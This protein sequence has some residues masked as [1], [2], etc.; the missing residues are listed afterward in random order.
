[1]HQGQLEI[2][3]V[4]HVPERSVS[5]RP[6]TARPYAIILA[7][8]PEDVRKGSARNTRR[9]SRSGHL[10]VVALVASRVSSS[11]GV[12]TPG[13]RRRKSFPFHVHARFISRRWIRARS[14]RS[15]RKYGRCRL[16]HVG[17]EVSAGPYPPQPLPS[18]I[19]ISAHPGGIGRQLSASHRVGIAEVKTGSRTSRG[20]SPG[21]DLACGATCCSNA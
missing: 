10:K 9:R 8:A 6:G 20:P 17:V 15:S 14:S 4:P 19:A 7:E 12:T 16:R 3:P 13:H 21:L 2:Q 11:S 18:S 5:A 1:V